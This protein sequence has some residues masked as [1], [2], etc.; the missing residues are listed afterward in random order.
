VFAKAFV[1]TFT[2]RAGRQVLVMEEGRVASLAVIPGV[3]PVAEARFAWGDLSLESSEL[4]LCLLLAVT[5]DIEVSL[6]LYK[7]FQRSVVR[8]LPRDGW[9]LTEQAIQR[10]LM[11]QLPDRFLDEDPGIIELGDQPA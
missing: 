7:A 2:R 3:L 11:Q 6:R 8:Y 10:W 1:G 9:A 4:A 5:D